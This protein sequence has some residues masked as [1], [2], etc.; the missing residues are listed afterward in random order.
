MVVF[1]GELIKPVTVTIIEDETVEELNEDFTVTVARSVGQPANI[2]PVNIPARITIRDDDSILLINVMLI[3]MK[4][5]LSDETFGLEKA[6]VSVVED[7]TFRVCVVLKSMKENCS[8]DFPFY[9]I[10]AVFGKNSSIS[11][12]S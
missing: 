10:L 11:T 4:F 2:I 9:L 5:S 7:L 3:A 1:S 12:P 6:S 8:V